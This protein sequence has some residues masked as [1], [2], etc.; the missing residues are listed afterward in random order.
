MKTIII[1]FATIVLCCAIGFVPLSFAQNSD[2]VVTIN[3]DATN[4][5][6]QNP[7]SSDNITVP[8]NATITWINNDI[9]FHQIVSGTPEE[10][11][12]NVFYGDYFGPGQTYNLTLSQP[13]VYDF[14]SPAFPNIKGVIT[15]TLEDNN[16]VG[17]DFSSGSG[18]EDGD[19]LDTSNINE[20]TTDMSSASPGSLVN[21]NENTLISNEIS[22][23]GSQGFDPF[24][25]P[26]NGS[27]QKNDVLESNSEDFIPSNVSSPISSRPLHAQTYADNRTGLQLEFS[28]K[29]LAFENVFEN[30]VTHIQLTNADLP[31][32]ETIEE[33]SPW[34]LLQ[35]SPKNPI[36]NEGIVFPY[37]EI[38]DMNNSKYYKDSGCEQTSS[39]DVALGTLTAK[40]VDFTCPFPFNPSIIVYQKALALENDNFQIVLVYSA[41]SILKYDEKLDEFQNIVQSIRIR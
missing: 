21:N 35:I 14:Y 12:S 18:I 20:F 34:I 2:V 40:E 8:V 24:E 16:N 13:G 36:T 38:I 1:I 41:Y 25:S 31:E 4:S 15:V 33:S 32:V 26:L 27:L 10:G 11:P 6:N 22:T 23:T 29:W 28:L 3:P 9:I 7:I 37:S 39:K 30:D 19:T 5:D 17:T